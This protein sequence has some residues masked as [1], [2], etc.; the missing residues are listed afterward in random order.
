MKNTTKI[1]TLIILTLTPTIKSFSQEITEENYLKMDKQIWETHEIKMSNVS[2][3]YELH[4]EKKDSLLIVANQLDKSAKIENIETAI[5]YASV[6][7]GFKRLYMV[8]LDIPKE[9]L[10]SVLEKLPIETQES[11]YGESIKLHINSKQIQEGDDFYNFQAIDSNGNPFQLSN[12]KGKDILLLYGGLDC[13]RE[14]GRTF[15]KNY[16]N[17]VNRDDYKVIVFNSSSNI[18]DLKTLKNKYNLDFIFVDDFQKDHSPMKIIYG[19]HATPTCFLINNN[20][21]ITK[22]SIGLPEK[23]LNE[24][25][26]NASS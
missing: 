23:E 16:Y 5:K 8:R 22:K 19:A 6:P 21:K 18:H 13:I 2:K 3:F 9:T 1:L 25:M 7:S 4:P 26:T 20:G 12:L 15:L 14:N 10:L 17:N 11:S 24:I